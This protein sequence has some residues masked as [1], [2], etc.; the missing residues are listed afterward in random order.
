MIE[1]WHLLLRVRV[2]GQGLFLLLPLLL[3]GLGKKQ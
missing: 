2:R 1:I 3:G